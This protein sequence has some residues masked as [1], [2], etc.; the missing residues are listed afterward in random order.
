MYN[1]SYRKDKNMSDTEKKPRGYW[2]NYDNCYNAAKECTSRMEFKKKYTAGYHKA[3][4]HKWLDDYTWF[5]EKPKFNYWDYDA[6]YKAALTCKTRSEFQKKYPGAHK[7]AWKNGWLDDY[8]WFERKANF[9]DDK[10]HNVYCYL[11]NEQHYVYVGRTND[12][13]ARD[14][15]HKHKVCPVKKFAD[16][17]NVSVPEITVL[18]SGLTLDESLIY[19][20]LYVEQY[21]NDGWNLINKGK[22]GLTSG[23][24]GGGKRPKWYKKS[25][26]DAALKCKTRNEFMKK[27]RSAYVRAWKMGWLND[28]YWLD[29]EKKPNGYWNYETCKEE[30]LKYNTIKD[31]NLQ[32]CGAYLVSL[33]NGWL[34]DFTWLQRKQKPNGYW[35]KERC[36]EIAKDCKTRAEFI[37]KCPAADSSAS[38]N[39]WIHLWFPT[40]QKPKDYWNYERCKNAAAECKTRTEF[41][42]KYNRAYFNSNKNHW[43]DEFFPKVAA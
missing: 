15:N 13:T 32:S 29:Y 38:R 7:P 34:D 31:F 43:L 2:D 40:T 22:T 21:K 16:K 33:E 25:C 6:C 12:I 28:Y 11:F 14:W 18:E 20:D 36:Y 24:I 1:H 26:Y 19:E 4:K 27:Y 10:V 30:S 39:G 8:Y 35:T 42:K 17:H 3:R 5:D 23:S 9:V 37:R 41:S